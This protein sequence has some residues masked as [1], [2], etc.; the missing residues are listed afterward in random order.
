MIFALILLALSAPLRA[1]AQSLPRALGARI[2]TLTSHPGFFSEPSVAVNPLN[3]QQ[4]VVAFQSKDHV[5]YSLDA[6]RHW[7]LAKGVAPSHYRVSGDVSVVYDNKGHAILC[8][9]AFDKLGTDQYWAHNATRNGI[10]VRRSLDGGKTWEKRLISV[11]AHASDPGIPFED[12][13]YIVADDTSGPYAGTLYVGWTHF[14]LTESEIYFSR[15]TDDGVTW[16]QPAV[17]STHPGLPRDD[18]GDVEGFTG[19]VTPDGTLC[20]AWTDGYHIVYTASHDGGRTFAPTR[21]IINTAPAYFGIGGVSRC[22]GFPEIAA[23]P[24]NGL[25]YVTW[26]DYR[27]GDVD[28]FASTSND[29]GR[30]WSAAVRVNNDAVHDGADQFFQWPAVDP[31][32]GDVYVVFYDRRGDPSNQN[33]VVVL[34]RSTDEGRTF[35][36]YAWSVKPFDAQGDFIG[37]YTGIAVY[38]GRVYGAWTERPALRFSRKG[39][40]TIVRVGVADLGRQ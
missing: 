1:P 24:R 23:N 32:T 31:V 26:G 16:S 28:V 4:V 25:L 9:I 11:I 8:S 10:F 3:P 34:A 22:N 40:Q 39:H 37:D 14:T 17:I 12:K 7:Q 30:T 19:A 20:V 18:N 6:G 29:H 21:D 2:F 36:N 5:A 33:A 35:A 38:N 27:N 13:P 15:S